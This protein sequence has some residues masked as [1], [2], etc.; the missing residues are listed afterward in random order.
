MTSRHLAGSAF[1]LAAVILLPCLPA[2]WPPA[3]AQE[4][5]ASLIRAYWGERDP[6]V[7]AAIARRL[8]SRA[9]Y[10][11]SRLREWLHAGVPFD[12]LAPGT[13]TITL[14]VPGEGARTVVLVLPEGYRPDRA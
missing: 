9:D 5:P 1:L 6:A 14:D 13:R 7:R 12:D 2:S 11:P 10:R 3:A 8:V 4:E